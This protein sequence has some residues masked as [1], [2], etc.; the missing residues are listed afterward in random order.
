[1]G[2]RVDFLFYF[3][4]KSEKDLF[5]LLKRNNFRHVIYLDKEGQLAKLNNL[6]DD[7]NYR[8]YL[9]NRNNEIVLVGNPIVNPQIWQLYKQA[10]M[11]DYDTGREQFE[12]TTVGVEQKEMELKGLKIGQIYKV[13]FLLENT[14]NF[15][16]FLNDISASCGCTIPEYEHRCVAPGKKTKITIK[17]TPPSLGYFRKK[18]TVFCNI[19][20][21]S[22]QL[23][24]K[25]IVEK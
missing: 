15:P 11:G 13:D 9:L 4:P 23:I 7:I 21:G 18:L 1:M 2:K 6:P 5:Y 16:L 3:Q 22:I 20:E 10:I 25:G 14:G 17:I 12:I 19:K 8:C 24:L